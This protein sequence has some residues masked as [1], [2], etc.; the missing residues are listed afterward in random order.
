MLRVFTAGESHGKALVGFIEGMP[1]NVSMNVEEINRDLARRQQGYGRGDRMK[2]EKD[3][4]EILSGIR[5]GKTL[6]SPI[7]FI[8]PNKDYENWTEYMSPI[9]TNKCDKLVTKPRPGHADLT[10]MLKYNFDDIRNVIERS[11]A[12]ET[13][14]RVAAGSLIKQFMSYFNITTHSHVTAIGDIHLQEIITDTSRIK[15]SDSSSVRCVDGIV[16]KKMIQLIEETKKAGD[17][18]GGI[19]EIHISG[20]PKGLG[21]YVHW[22]RKLDAKLS[23][24]LMSIQGVKGVELGYGFQN[25]SRVGSLVHDEILFQKTKGFFRNTNHAGGIEGGMSNGENI[26]IRC[27]MKPIPT[28]YK[29]LKT[30]DIESKESALATVERSDTCAVPAAS[31]VG[32]M[33]AITVIA[34][35]FLRKFGGDS[36]EEIEKRWKEYI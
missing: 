7:S 14:V 12:R 1:S 31:I 17:S 20:V 21:S 16:E 28:L 3:K 8:I 2:I 32:E 22:D 4:I 15:E 26:V 13:A 18:L 34:E 10:G 11:S 30:V 36:L 5:G 6:G 9:N 35:E 33:V 29:P 25:T 24:A 27:G 19:F 23:Y